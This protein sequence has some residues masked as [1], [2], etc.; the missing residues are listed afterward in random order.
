MTG[1]LVGTCE[2]NRSSVA[3]RMIAD[4]VVSVSEARATSSGATCVVIQSG[5]MVATRFVSPV[6]SSVAGATMTIF[7]F[8]SANVYRSRIRIG[9]AHVHA[10]AGL[11]D[12]SIHRHRIA[13]TSMQLDL[14]KGRVPG[15]LVRDPG[16]ACF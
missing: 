15:L 2:T 5:L 16:L 12:I 9:P 10:V 3:A 13:C 4:A 1:M 7:F 11:D 8:S 14:L 6:P